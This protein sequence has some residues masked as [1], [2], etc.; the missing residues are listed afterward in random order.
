MLTEET[1]QKLV[2]LRLNGIVTALREQL[3]NATRYRKM[4]F[5]DRLGLLVDRE[6]SERH[7]RR[8]TRRLQQARLRDPQA[9]LE[10]LN[11]QVARGLERTTIRRLGTCDWLRK[12]E[13]VLVVGPTGVGKTFVACALAHKACRD[14]YTAM[15]RRFPRFLQEL[16]LARHDGSYPRLL[17]KVAKTDLIVLDDW[18]IKPMTD[19]ERRDILEVIED[20]VGTGSV[21]VTSQLPVSKWHEYIGD[22]TVADAILDRIVHAA[23]ELTMKGPS[24]RK[25][26]AKQT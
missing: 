2:D 9:C 10:D 16:K 1:I 15:Y 5:E 3:E 20:R 14:G 4:T 17:Q 23:H 24:M 13:H 25:R 18:G 19:E 21:V 12:H 26:Q 11:L 8:L 7:Q 6:W 22:P